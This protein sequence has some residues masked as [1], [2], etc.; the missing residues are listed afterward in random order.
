MS[1]RGMQI[2]FGENVRECGENGVLSLSY[3]VFVIILLFFNA[4][5]M[6][7]YAIIC[8]SVTTS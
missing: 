3:Q 5:I 8:S 7:G 4:Q 2:T 1:R 6:N